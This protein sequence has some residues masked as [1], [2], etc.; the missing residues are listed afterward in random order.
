MDQ[1]NVKFENRDAALESWADQIQTM[2]AHRQQSHV[3]FSWLLADAIAENDLYSVEQAYVDLRLYAPSADQVLCRNY[4]KNTFDNC[5]IENDM[6]VF[7]HDSEVITTDLANFNTPW[8]SEPKAKAKSKPKAKQKRDAAIEIGKLIATMTKMKDGELPS[9]N[10]KFAAQ[11]LAELVQLKADWEE[12]RK[13]A[14]E[15][16]AK[17][18]VPVPCKAVA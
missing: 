4:L 18:E 17:K 8:Y 5:D 13:A 16:K 11:E 6:L 3:A 15:T 9:K 7:D 1:E 12:R 10:T 14:P 2:G